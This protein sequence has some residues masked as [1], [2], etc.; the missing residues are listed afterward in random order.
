VTRAEV[1][2]TEG[3]VGMEDP[4]VNLAVEDYSSAGSREACSAERLVVQQSV[5]S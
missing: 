5:V 2:M 4:V 1:A 3:A